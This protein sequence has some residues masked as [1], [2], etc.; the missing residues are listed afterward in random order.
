M[1]SHLL[2][3]EFGEV[4]KILTDGADELKPYFSG[5]LSCEYC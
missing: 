1:I 4:G 5:N 2:S 3:D